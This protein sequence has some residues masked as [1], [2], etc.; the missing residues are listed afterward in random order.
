MNITM[1]NCRFHNNT[2]NSLFTTSPYQGSA[3]G[4]SIGYNSADSSTDSNSTKQPIHDNNGA[5]YILSV[6][7]LQDGAHVLITNCTFTDNSARILPSQ[8]SSSNDA[9]TNSIFPGRGGAVAVLVNIDIPFIFKFTDNIVMNNYAEAFGGG[10]YCITRR[11]S[12]QTYIFSSSTFVNN[13]GTKVGGLA[14]LYVLNTLSEHAVHNNVCNCKFYNNN[15]SE[16]AGAAIV[17]AV[18]GIASNIFVTFKECNFF[19]NMAKVYGGAVSITSY[20]FFDSIEKQSLVNF[21]NW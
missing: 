8:T 6:P 9:L 3:G 17:A 14:L 20:D 10:V 13:W 16:I 21:H 19:N 7:S 11:R 15:A 2:S 1:K 5:V 12:N 18:Y 4:C